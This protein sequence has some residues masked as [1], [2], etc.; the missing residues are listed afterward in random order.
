LVRK[1]AWETAEGMAVVPLIAP[2][3]NSSFSLQ[4]FGPTLQCNDANSSQ[5][6]AF[7][8]YT[9]AYAD[10][11][12]TFVCSQLA[13]LNIT[14]PYALV[15]SAFSSTLFNGDQPFNNINQFP[16]PYSNLVTPQIWVQTGNRSIVCVLANASFDVGFEFSSGVQNLYQRKIEV[17]NELSV[18]STCEGVACIEESSYFAHFLAWTNMLNGNV[19]MYP[20]Y[21]AWELVEVSSNMLITGLA[22]C[23]EIANSCWDS[24]F[25]QNSPSFH[26]PN[27]TDNNFPGALWGCRN[28][29]IDR[30]IEDLANNITISMLSSPSLT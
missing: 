23:D 2:A 6:V 29:T 30:G 21:D 25:L 13:T 12:G 17:I 16:S 14:P 26:I 7:D 18:T 24:I 1:I 10:P 11:S 8:S 5:Q 28:H 19:T 9:A 4:F 3:T 20:G 22:T 27:V 15:F